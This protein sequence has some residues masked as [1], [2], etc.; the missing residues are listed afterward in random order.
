MPMDSQKFSK[1]WLVSGL[2]SDWTV[3]AVVQAGGIEAIVTAMEYH[4]HDADI[5]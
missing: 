2:Y 4:P 1:P 5:Q 3:A